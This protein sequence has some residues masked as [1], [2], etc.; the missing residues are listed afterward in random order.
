MPEIVPFCEHAGHPVYIKTGRFGAYIAWDGKTITL[1]KTQIKHTT[2]PKTK[3]ELCDWT[4]EQVVSVIE[5]RFPGSTTLSISGDS[6]LPSPIQPAKIEY[7]PGNY[8]RKR[9]PR[10]LTPFLLLC[11]NQRTGAFLLRH[12][13][14][15]QTEPIIY[16]IEDYPG[17][18]GKATDESLLA[19]ASARWSF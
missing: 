8:Q 19:W 15:N 12:T 5:T 14:P 7:V 6:S 11:K 4:P 18:P 2:E 17:D 16:C 10:K 1:P 3:K 13:P 9:V